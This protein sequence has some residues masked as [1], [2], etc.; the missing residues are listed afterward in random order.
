MRVFVYGSLMVPGV[1][2]A[3][4]G[5][6]PSRILGA[7]LYGFKR[8]ALE[9]CS[10]PGIRKH[11]GSVVEGVVLD[12]L[13]SREIEILDLFEEVG[14]LYCRES[15]QV[16]VPGAEDALECQVYLLLER[17]H[18]RLDGEWELNGFLENHLQE[19]LHVCRSFRREIEE[20]FIIQ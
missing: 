17:F 2:E 7:K 19:F 18:G 3:V 20:K 13:G 11:S 1:L 15:V 6:V 12:G 16:A 8:F 14:E 9:N 4:L 5:R 10:Y